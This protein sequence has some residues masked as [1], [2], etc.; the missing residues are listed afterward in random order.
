MNSI[1]K[2][3][4][5]LVFDY[6]NGNEQALACLIHRHKRQIFYSI[7]LLIKNKEEAED[8]FQDTF[9]KVVYSL[10]SGNYYEDGKFLPWVMRIAKNL[11][12]DHF[13]RLK[14]MPMIPNLVNEDGEDVDIFSILN[15]Q[16][17]DSYSIEKLELKKNIRSL[18]E[19]LPNEQKEVLLMRI[20]YDMSFK[21]IADFTSVSIN[22]AL[23]RMRYALINLKKMM[24]AENLELAI[25][26]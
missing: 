4:D 21:E 26:G 7:S 24:E 10:K 1:L 12:I 19:K 8:V 20:Y 15:I 13:R 5:Q 11:V 9:V 6:V 17:N 3:D 25:A 23:G 2:S 18:I 14:K 22:T 16:K